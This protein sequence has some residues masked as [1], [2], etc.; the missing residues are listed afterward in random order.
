MYDEL[1][2]LIPT[3]VSYQKAVIQTPSVLTVSTKGTATFHCDITKDERK[4]VNWYKQVPGGAPQYVLRFY[5]SWSSSTSSSSDKYGSG[6]SSD[7]FT[8]KATSDKDYQFIISNVEETGTALLKRTYHSDI[9]H[10][11]NLLTKYTHFCF[12]MF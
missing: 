11:K 8:S 4:V 3:D 7:H 12:Q 5:H 1:S 9:H 2:N 6:F 10:D